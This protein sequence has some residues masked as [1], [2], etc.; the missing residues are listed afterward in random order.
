M[1]GYVA[2]T[3]E[4][5]ASKRWRA[6]SNFT[7]AAHDS[8]APLVLAEIGAAAVAMPLAFVKNGEQFE[9]V[10]VLAYTVGE[11]VF[12]TPNGQWIGRYVPVVYRTRPFR[13]LRAENSKDTVLCVE[14]TSDLVSDGG[15]G[16]PF[17]AHGGEPSSALKANMELLQHAE[18]SRQMTAA[19]ASALH[20]AGLVEEWPVTI[21]TPT[22]EAQRIGGL[23]RV[24][25]AA[26]AAASD[27]TYLQLRRT[28]AIPLAYA[29]LFSCALLNQL[30][31]LA[32]FQSQAKIRA[33]SQ[34][35]ASGEPPKLILPSDDIIRFD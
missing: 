33:Q 26:L 14:E 15:E 13:F 18:R 16:E 27:D 24:N 30:A 5:H 34:A 2:V 25:E 1:T 32:K 20:D 12:V 35:S 7:F 17:F 6:P 22:G 29:Q 11:N 19:A 3:P 4:Q 10:A 28:H 9:L 21:Q 31:E 8:V 23:Y